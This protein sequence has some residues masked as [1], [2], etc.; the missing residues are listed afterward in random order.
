MLLLEQRGMDGVALFVQDSKLDS[1]K[2]D[3]SV[4]AI[5][6]SAR[7]WH[8]RVQATAKDKLSKLADSP[9]HQGVV[10]QASGDFGR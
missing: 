3:D 1:N 7:L 4:Q 10:L 8:Q 9:Q 5:L 6:T 2:L